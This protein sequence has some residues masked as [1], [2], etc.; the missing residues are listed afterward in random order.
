LANSRGS[1]SVGSR[2]SDLISASSLAADLNNFARIPSRERTSW[3]KSCTSPAGRMRMPGSLVCCSFGATTSSRSWKA[4]TN[5]WP[6]YSINCKGTTVISR[7]E[8][9]SMD[10][11]MRE[12]SERGP[13]P[14]RIYKR[15]R[16]GRVTVLFAVPHRSIQFHRVRSLSAKGPSNDTGFS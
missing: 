14:S 9:C 10:A 12:P 4:L 7:S 15:R 2:A 5:V 6:C 1:D 16:S 3:P 13:W 11:S 8:S